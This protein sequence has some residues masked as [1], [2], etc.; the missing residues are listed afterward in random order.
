MRNSASTNKVLTKKCLYEKPLLKFVVLI[1]VAESNLKNQILVFYLKRNI[2]Q[3]KVRTYFIFTTFL[4]FLPHCNQFFV[5]SFPLENNNYFSNLLTELIHSWVDRC[6]KILAHKEILIK[7]F[8][9]IF[10][11]HGPCTLIELCI[12]CA[13]KNLKPLPLANLLTIKSYFN[14]SFKRL[15]IVFSKGLIKPSHLT[16]YCSRFISI[17]M[18]LFLKA[19]CLTFTYT[20]ILKFQIWVLLLNQ[21]LKHP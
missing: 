19:H 7:H 20:E 18:S 14:N 16:L 3:E 5:K 6:L 4:N 1:L 21:F 2:K 10:P 11:H 12:K 9:V 13:S 17:I 8:W 15:F